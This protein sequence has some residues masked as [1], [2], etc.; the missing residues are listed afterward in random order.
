MQSI[1]D[2]NKDILLKEL[3][4]HI[5]N[6]E[7]PFISNALFAVALIQTLKKKKKKKLSK[8]GDKI[9]VSCNGLVDK[10]LMCHPS[11]NRGTKLKNH[12]DNIEYEN[13]RD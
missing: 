6:L 13:K 2:K 7:K 4:E 10:L 12:N 5:S 8:A 3:L 11:Y 1:T 9:R